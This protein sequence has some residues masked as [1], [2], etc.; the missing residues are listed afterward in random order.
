MSP[1][2][3]LARLTAEE[4]RAALIEGYKADP[5]RAQTLREA[6]GDWEAAFKLGPFPSLEPDPSLPPVPP[7]A[8]TGFRSNVPHFLWTGLVD[9]TMF[10]ELFEQHRIAH[11]PEPP[12]VLD[13]GCGPG[14]IA[15][16]LS[17]T[18]APWRL[19]GFE[20]NPETADWTQRNL[21]NIDV[22][23]GKRMPPSNYPDRCFDFIYSYSVFTHTVEDVSRAWLREFSRITKPGAI[24]AFTTTGG[25]V[26]ERLSKSSSLRERFR[27]SPEEVEQLRA[28]MLENGFALTSFGHVGKVGA[29]LGADYG[30][31]FVTPERLSEWAGDAF[32]VLDHRPGRARGQDINVLRARS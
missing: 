11:P 3:F 15:R 25:A 8:G 27:L 9:A 14:R 21:P 19:R 12:T 7:P 23:V 6:G 16:Y 10:V 30:W 18:T 28:T 5:E 22:T 20:I 13:F 4:L 2:P 29:I 32:A 26:L 31:A 24:V 17:A 1:R